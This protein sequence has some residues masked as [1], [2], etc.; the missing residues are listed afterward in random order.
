MSGDFRPQRSL[1]VD[2]CQF[3]LTS[4]HHEFAVVSGTL[5]RKRA[6]ER[7]PRR[8][9]LHATTCEPLPSPVW[10]DEKMVRD[11]VLL[12]RDKGTGNDDRVFREGARLPGRDRG[13]AD[14]QV[15]KAQR[16]TASKVRR[17]ES[18]RVF[19]V[20]GLRFF[21][22]RRFDRTF[23]CALKCLDIGEKETKK[24]DFE[25]MLFG[26][27]FHLVRFI[28]LSRDRPARQLHAPYTHTPSAAFD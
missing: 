6:T 20:F 5:A 14:A 12:R 7:G 9:D 11:L 8:D 27:S 10:C 17:L 23:L 26:Q 21:V 28:R 15:L 1:D 2:D 25:L 13:K 4:I 18:A 3:A 19:V 16:M 24:F 22:S